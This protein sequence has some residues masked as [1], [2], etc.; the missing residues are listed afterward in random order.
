[1]LLRSQKQLDGEFYESVSASVD[2]VSASWPVLL[3]TAHDV[4][5]KQPLLF[6]TQVYEKR[7]IS[8]TDKALQT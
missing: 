7:K 8:A 3:S 4:L 1:M 2:V 6:M 5:T